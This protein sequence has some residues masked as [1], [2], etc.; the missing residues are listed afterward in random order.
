MELDLLLLLLLAVATYSDRCILT[1]VHI[2]L[3]HSSGVLYRSS[4]ADYAGES[5]PP[6]LLHLVS[7]PGSLTT[8]VP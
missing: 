6:L 3:S 2:C 8:T 1:S 7:E 4:D 5:S